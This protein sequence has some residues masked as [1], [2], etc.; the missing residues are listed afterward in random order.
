M[1]GTDQQK[2][3]QAGTAATGSGE[4]RTPSASADRVCPSYSGGGTL[5]SNITAPPDAS[6]NSNVM[7]GDNISRDVNNSFS[8]LE[9]HVS[10]EKLVLPDRTASSKN[11]DAADPDESADPMESS[12]SSLDSCPEREIEMV[13]GPTGK[14]WAVVS[15]KRKR[16][17]RDSS[18][19]ADSAGSEK[20]A[21]LPRIT[22]AK[23]GKGP[24]RPTSGRTSTKKAGGA[25]SVAATPGVSRLSGSSS[26]SDGMTAAAIA[27]KLSSAINRV[28]QVARSSRNLK[29]TSVKELN[30][31]VA[32]LEN[33]PL[34]KPT[35]STEM[36]ALQDKNIRQQAEIDFLRKEIVD[37]KKS[38]TAA[39][40][41]PAALSPPA[42]ASSVATTRSSV[43]KHKA[44]PPPSATPEPSWVQ[45]LKQGF[46]L[47]IGTMINARFD[48]IEDRLLPERRS[49]PP[50]AATSA[51]EAT[52]ENSAAIVPAP[53][54]V[55]KP[56]PRRVLSTPA[57]VG[58]APQQSNAGP[59]SALSKSQRV[60]QRR[61][62]AT[63]RAAEQLTPV[64]NEP[65]AVSASAPPP[66]T[67]QWSQ[68]AKRGAKSAKK[69]RQAP[70]SQQT[71]R[72]NKAPKLRAPRSSAVVL[73]LQPQAAQNGVTY[74]KVLA[75]AKHKVDFGSLNLPGLRF[76]V[77]A[78]GAR[79]LVL[80]G[81]GSGEKAD[82]LAEKLRAAVG[83]AVHVSRPT[84][85]VEM[86]VSGLDDSVT[87]AEVALAVA[88]AGECKTEEVKTGEIRRNASGLG[89]V[90]VRLPIAAAKKAAKGERILVGFVSA[91]VRLLESRPQQCFRCL[92]IG[93][94]RA[95]CTSEHDRSGQCYRCG[96]LGHKSAGCSNTPH[97]SVCAVNNKPADHCVGSKFCA[98]QQVKRRR[99]TR[100]GGGPSPQ[101]TRAEEVEMPNQ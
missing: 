48:N 27:K 93:H 2:L 69:T 26:E 59:S 45:E 28:S 94:V 31:A 71:A 86:R 33:L 37:L 101:S 7:G 44:G 79:M 53:V 83:E 49:R 20:S 66:L 73:T 58:A 88:E 34:Q 35:V 1:E 95:Q 39:Y 40:K 64:D 85:C 47:E 51:L 55:P 68:V 3:P 67:E 17:K 15:K 46:M 90:W 8:L 30:E 10:L 81:A 32:I 23:R 80:P 74:A 87:P 18:S 65:H 82:A 6:G 36:K 99:P 5:Y 76:R 61:I 22:T 38:L 97:C 50:L 78:T 4:S 24:R 96:E 92:E 62:A 13:E 57:A 19:C 54:P 70:M 63:K 29:G 21:S 72:Q 25:K 41:I 98:A 16:D 52:D 11:A 14:V 75:E 43:T 89:T 9:C 56:A 42:A 12:G 60:R 84:K 77:A 100:G 91:Q